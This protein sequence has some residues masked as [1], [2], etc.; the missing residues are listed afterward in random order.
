MGSGYSTMNIHICG[1]DEDNKES[2]ESQMKIL[3]ILFPNEDEEK[4]TL[5]YTV[6][7]SSKPKWNAF[8]YSDKNSKNFNIINQTIQGLLIKFNIENQKR[9]LSIE[10]EGEFK[11]NIILLFVNDN[12]SDSL[13]CEEF[14]KE[15]TKAELVGNFPL[16]LFIF[17][18]I[19][20]DNLYYKEKFFDFSYIKCLNMS[21]INF[22]KYKNKETKIEEFQA[23]FL[24]YFLF[25]NFDSY[26]T[27]RGYKI[28]DE[29]DPILNN[30]MTGVYLPIILVGSPGVGKSTFINVV[31]GRKISKSSDSD[32][33]VTSK[34]AYY[35]I[36][37]PGNETVTHETEDEELKQ[38]IFIRF[39]DT[40]GFDL[41]KDLD[42]ALNEIQRIFNDF[43]EGKERLPIVLYF[44]NP[45]GRN[46]S[47]DENKSQKRM[48]IFKVLQKNKAKI[49]FVITNSPKNKP[50]RKQATFI[51]FIKDNKLGNLIEKDNSN[52]IKCDLIGEDAYGV[53]E[54]FKKIYTYL[55]I[56]RENDNY[57][58]TGEVYN[59]TLIE[60][61]KKLS[62]FDEKLKYIKS[63]T[64]LFD[65]FQTKED[66]IIYAKKRS[67]FLIRSM[68]ATSAAIGSIPIPFA[69]I[70]FVLSIIG[71]S[72]TKIGKYYGYV[73]KEISKKD[74][75]AIY[76]GELCKE[77]KNNNDETNSMTSERQIIKIFG[78]MAVK[79]LGTLIA[80]NVDDFLKSCWG[81]GSIIGMAIG[82]VADAGLVYN[83]LSNANNYFES[84]CRLDDG[85]IFFCTRCAEYEAIFKRF[86]QFENYDLVY[87]TE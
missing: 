79:G 5:F 57:T 85:T 71:S 28:I 45:I 67:Q 66:I 61:I 34:S 20:R 4:K 14:T 80:L 87:P 64:S 53:K 83:Y 10:E 74:L 25:N 12:C 69:D 77:K 24:K 37:I 76:N 59:H 81:I 82:A 42:N 23:L 50:W 21:S 51:K 22:E 70:A 56:I 38:E 8:I 9:K 84:K 44:M 33:P 16:I 29:V 11:N 27:E 68:M 52:I 49:I 46:S 78:E 72:I 86:K 47:K 6:K 48:E 41:E 31:N 3:N 17:K 7:Y 58:P 73:W 65:E 2:Y 55:N 1:L 26:F 39:I 32:D 43:K 40:P 60:E 13:L 54:I 36:K 19:D 30:Q 18:D 62:T 63:K 35:D 75:Q 15:E